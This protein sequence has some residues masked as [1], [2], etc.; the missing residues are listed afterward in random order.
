MIPAPIPAHL[1]D[2]PWYAPHQAWLRDEGAETYHDPGA[3]AA[4]RARLDRASLVC[5]D[6]D[7][8]ILDRA[9]L[10]D[11]ILDHARLDGS[12]LDGARLDRASL[13]GARL[14]GCI[15]DRASLVGA[16]LDRARLDGSSLVGCILDRARL[17]DAS[18]VGA[19]LVRASLEPIRDDLFTVLDAAPNEVAALREAIVAGNINGS[20][21]GGACCC[22]VGTLEKARGGG[23]D[24]VVVRNPSRPAEIWFMALMPGLT[25]E[26]NEVARVTLGWIDQWT[27]EHTG[28]N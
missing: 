10:V 27:T 28:A 2:Y 18:L 26:N 23:R 24:C 5:A 19:S 13:I 21:Y 20:C 4:E 25:P 17:V 8:C 6:L 12:S 15:L 22:L 11:A 7:G 14:D 1:A 3:A 9:S 16:D